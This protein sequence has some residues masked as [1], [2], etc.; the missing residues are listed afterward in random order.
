MSAP[1]K[2]NK[3]ENLMAMHPSSWSP[4]ERAVLYGVC[5]RFLRPFVQ[6]PLVCKG[7]LIETPA[8]R[9][10]FESV[11]EYEDKQKRGGVTDFNLAKTF[12]DLWNGLMT[13]SQL[14]SSKKVF[15]NTDEMKGISLGTEGSPPA[16]NPCPKI[17]RLRL[18]LIR[19][20]VAVE[21]LF[22][23]VEAG[24]SRLMPKRAAFL[25]P[26]LPNVLKYSSQDYVEDAR[27]WLPFDARWPEDLRLAARVRAMEVLGGNCPYL[28]EVV[29]RD[30]MPD[31]SQGLEYDF[32]ELA[33]DYILRR[34]RKDPDAG[35]RVFEKF[36]YRMFT[37]YEK[38]LSEPGKTA[39]YTSI[40]NSL[41]TAKPRGERL[42]INPK[43]FK[44]RC[45]GLLS[46]L[47]G[48]PVD[49]TMPLDFS[50]RPSMES[51]SPGLS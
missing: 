44:I 15:V 10:L 29:K 42:H 7:N 5:E 40:F 12:G 2:V 27:S 28:N 1:E 46:S 51:G 37:E 16:E 32:K 8:A 24:L 47:V 38:T 31:L 50:R 41:E 3:F 13:T 33:L 36:Y 21:N 39:F 43:I 23:K 6:V 17:S 22:G 25:F 35:K 4:V 20:A 34:P 49:W 9:E 48:R 18:G 11:F 45:G 26:L 14:P 30:K 19:S